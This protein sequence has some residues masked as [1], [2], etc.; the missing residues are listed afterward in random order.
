MKKIFSFSRT[1]IYHYDEPVYLAEND[2]LEPIVPSSIVPAIDARE[3][4]P[5]V[6]VPGHTGPGCARDECLDVPVRMPQL[7][8]PTTIPLLPHGF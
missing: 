7:F 5:G 6:R 4:L 2:T 8:L 1:K 3:L